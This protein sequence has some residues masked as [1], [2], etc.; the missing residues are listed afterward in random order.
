MLH[1]TSK[2]IDI[3]PVSVDQ[4]K[5]QCEYS[6]DSGKGPLRYIRSNLDD[7][8]NNYIHT[9]VIFVMISQYYV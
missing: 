7:V 1:E 6:P 4:D 2:E 9:H 8:L 3:D 5:G